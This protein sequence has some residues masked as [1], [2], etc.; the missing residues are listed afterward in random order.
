[1][2]IVFYTSLEKLHILTLKS[3]IREQ[4]LL[5]TENFKLET[6]STERIRQTFYSLREFVPLFLYKLTP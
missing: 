3:G 1:M 5:K 4:A 2:G 6:V